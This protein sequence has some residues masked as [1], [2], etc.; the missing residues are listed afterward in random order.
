VLA[1]LPFENLGDSADA[2]F[3]E[4]VANEVRSKLTQL[5]GLAVIARV[6]SNEYRRTHRRPEE[7]AREL[8]AEYLLTGTVQWLRGTGGT[9]RVRVS[10]E[11]LE[12]ARGRAPST[13]WA[14]PFDAA[15]TDVFQVQADIAQKVAGALGVALADSTRRGLS[16][17]PTTNLGA[18]DAYL[19][20]EAAS[21]E[22]SSLVAD[23]RRSLGFYEQAVA[24]DSTYLNAWVQLAR[25]RS[26]LI[27]VGGATPGL[28]QAALAAVERAERLAPDR[29]ES[30]LARV[31]Y[32]VYVLQDAPQAIA[33]ASAGLARAPNDA[34]LLAGAALAER[35]G[36]RWEE[37]LR[38]ALRAVRLDPRSAAVA[39]VAGEDLVWMRRYP[40]AR[41]ELDR[42]AA[43]APL[44]GYIRLLRVMSSLGQ[45]NLDEARRL[46]DAAEITEGR[47]KVITSLA[48]YNDLYWVL[49]EAQQQELLH[50]TP[51]AFDGD[52]A[53]WAH[54]RAQLHAL[55]GETAL[56]RV[57][58]DTAQ[59]EFAAQL[60]GVPVS[61]QSAQ[62]HVLRAIDLAY[63]GRKSE[64]IDE[65]TLA[66][67]T[68]PVSAS[69]TD[70]VYFQHQFVRTLVL[71]GEHERALD[72][73][74]PLLEIPYFVSPSWLR[75]DPNFAPLRGNPRF[76]RLV[77]GG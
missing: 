59:A 3:A 32:C 17:A 73:L 54:V 71:L 75:I 42:G 65:A 39:R 31:E 60:A 15:L 66:T 43:L 44:N 11:L 24:L 5:G 48:S 52:R 8:G 56:A 7:I 40:Q 2:Y 18:Y 37:S 23:V 45:G 28:E 29:P 6:S 69:H 13:K 26:F 30:R 41:A 76:E 4:G 27:W 22:D 33:A 57:W 20:A 25:L 58:A 50:L 61:R 77:A 49:R 34:D 38:H 68:V 47:L 67:T 9:S 63:L 12:V 51:A 36:G 46:V 53:N 74:E 72:M 64:A 10:P 14:Q 62:A 1:V 19:K 16:A 70:G 35:L 21:V 55:R